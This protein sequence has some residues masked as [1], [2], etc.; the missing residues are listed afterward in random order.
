MDLEMVHTLKPRLY[1][2]ILLR[3]LPE[4]IFG[5]NAW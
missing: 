1:L 2:K 4:L 3:T 5:R